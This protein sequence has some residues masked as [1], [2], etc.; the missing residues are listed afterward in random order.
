MLI[1]AHS[2]WVALVIVDKRGRITFG[3]LPSRITLSTP[4]SFS[5]NPTFSLGGYEVLLHADKLPFSLIV[6]GSLIGLEFWKPTTRSISTRCET[7][8]YHADPM[9]TRQCP[10]VRYLPKWASYFS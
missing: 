2:R 5:F 6:A 9:P 1:L 8:M 7:E 10:N 4:L 3:R